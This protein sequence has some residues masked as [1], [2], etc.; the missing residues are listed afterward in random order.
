MG[1]KKQRQYQCQR[2]G[3]EVV[4]SDAERRYC[5]FCGVSGFELDCVKDAC[6]PRERADESGVF[7]LPAAL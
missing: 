5:V 2:C 6:L 4:G 1:S 3:A 7:R